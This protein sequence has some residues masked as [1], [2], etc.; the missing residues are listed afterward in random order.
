LIALSIN[1][2]NEEHKKKALM[3]TNIK[4]MYHDIK[5][6]TF[7]LQEVHTS[8]LNQIGVTK[9]I[10]PIIESKNRF[11]ADSLKFIKILII[12]QLISL[13]QQTPSN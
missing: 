12:P 7:D 3:I 5:A 10:V 1:N 6:D 9:N 4:A 13:I 8:L 2:W 11:I